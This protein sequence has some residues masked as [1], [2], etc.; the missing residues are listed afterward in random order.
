VEPLF[1]LDAVTFS[2]S[3]QCVLGALDMVVPDH[4]VTAL[5]GPSGSGKSTV[6]RLCNRLLV[7][8][9]G[10]VRFRGSKV[11]EIDPCTLRRRV[12]MVFQNPIPFAGTVSDNL[13]VAGEEDPAEVA[14]LLERVGLDAGFADRDA[15]K[16]SGGETQR[17]CLAR[18]LATRPEALLV[19]EGTSA[20]DD[21]ATATL[22][23]LVLEEA[24]GGCPV[25]WVTHDL[26]QAER[27][28]AHRIQMP[29]PGPPA[30]PRR[31]SCSG[32]LG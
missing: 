31:D 32:D 20:L 4:G 8:D 9:E 21:A 30:D 18:T 19:D 26:A 27:I 25:L 29:E 17:M 23:A 16:L 7:P 28:A 15:R 5:T 6:L 2:R 14:R 12:G 10:E 22:E 13:A 3:G 1:E 11:A 24:R